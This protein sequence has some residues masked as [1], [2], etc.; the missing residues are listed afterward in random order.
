[1]SFWDFLGIEGKQGPPGPKGDPG[2]PGRTGRTGR[3]GPA[4][5]PP[6]PPGP[7]GP[8]GSP[9]PRGE[10]GP[11]GYMSA[12]AIHSKLTEKRTHN[13]YR[14]NIDNYEELINRDHRKFVIIDGAHDPNIRCEGRQCPDGYV[15][16]K[17][18]NEKNC[19]QL[20]WSRDH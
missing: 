18:G 1:M 6:G 3:Q 11:P 13:E 10:Q 4:G 12:Q 20:R 19:Y 9:G 5:G 14:Y 17:R 16:V 15:C 8:E 2:E 7:P